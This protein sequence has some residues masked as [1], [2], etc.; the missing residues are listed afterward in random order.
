MLFL[1]NLQSGMNLLKFLVV[2]LILI[3]IE[4]LIHSKYF[5]SNIVYLECTWLKQW[6]IFVRDI[7]SLIFHF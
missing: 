1:S 5:N 4:F 3:K 6:V 2:N 7:F